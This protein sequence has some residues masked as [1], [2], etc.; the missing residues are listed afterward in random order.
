[1][2]TSVTA[3]TTAIYFDAIHWD[4]MRGRRLTPAP[5][6]AP[7]P[8]PPLDLSGGVPHGLGNSLT[9]HTFIVTPHGRATAALDA[10]LAP[11]D[12]SS[13]IIYELADLD[14][15]MMLAITRERVNRRL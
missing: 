11:H 5:E 2:T 12:P 14:L 7:T 13:V 8:A 15:G 1:M 9:R 6:F 3:A 4:R 10:N